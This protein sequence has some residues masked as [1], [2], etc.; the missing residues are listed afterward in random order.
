MKKKKAII[1]LISVICLVLV[2]LLVYYIVT[3]EDSKTTLNIV[4][5]KWIESNKNMVYNV[6]ILSS[7]PIYSYKGEGIAFDFLSDI[8]E[9]TGLDFDPILYSS[10]T[11]INEYS[12]QIKKEL[13]ASDL[14]VGEDEY[15]IVSSKAGKYNSLDAVEGLT[16]GVLETDLSYVENYIKGAKLKSYSSIDVMLSAIDNI[17]GIAIPKIKYLK[18]IL[19]NNLN[20]VYNITELKSYY[21]FHLGQIEKLNSIVTKYLNKWVKENKESLYQE[22]LNSSYFELKDIDENARA[23]F[24]GKKYIYGFVNNSPYDVLADGKLLGLNSLIVKNFS[25]L[26]KIDLEIKKYNSFELLVEAFNKNEIDF[27]FNNYK[28]YQYNIDV[29]NTLSIYDEKVVILS[30]IKNDVTINS[31]S[32]IKEDVNTIADTKISEFLTGHSIN[33]VTYKTLS[34]LLEKTKEDALIVIDAY[35]YYYNLQKFEQYKID[36]TFSLDTGYTYIVRDISNNKVFT[37]YLNFYL[38]FINQKTVL[39]EG[40]SQVYNL[41]ET[42]GLKLGIILFVTFV[43]LLI[44]IIVLKKTLKKQKKIKIVMS[45]NDKLRYIDSLTCLKNRTYYNDFVEKWDNS[46][47]YPQAIIIVDLNNVAFINDNF[48]YQ[49]GDNVIREAS[50]ILINNQI[51]NTEII[52]SN[53]NEFLIYLIGYEEKQVLAY[54]KKLLREL[55]NLSHGFGAAAGYSM[56]LDEIKTIDDAVNEATTNMKN[57]KEESSE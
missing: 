27:A 19:S 49:E 7:I 28:E 34:E 50:S 51:E 24:E 12:F 32:S 54:V 23:I 47:I 39:N 15:V 42:D 14:I 3:R 21:V 20:I 57:N 8:E 33:T 52:R 22:Y 2:S 1:A 26:S 10:E 56:I 6:D 30:N 11:P 44:V 40:Y 37:D 38:G 29:K 35:T 31:L 13:E 46:M 17:D 55:K 53:G 41:K 36:F 48:G 43:G 9:D 4:D 18:E 16:I 25:S 45:K 5:K